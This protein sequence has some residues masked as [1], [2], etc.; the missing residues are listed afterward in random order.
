MSIPFFH[1]SNTVMV[2]VLA[3]DNA[4]VI[5][6]DAVPGQCHGVGLILTIGHA[7]MKVAAFW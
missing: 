6:G 5:V 3:F 4:V 2:G 1:Q 7:K